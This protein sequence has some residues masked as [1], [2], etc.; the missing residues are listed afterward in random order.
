MAY[1]LVTAA[2]NEAALIERTLRSVAAQTILPK[3]WIIVSDGST[4]RTEEIARTYAARLPF[5]QVIR[6]D[7]DPGRSFVSKVY[8]VQEGFRRVRGLPFEFVGNLDADLSFDATYFEGLLNKFQGDPTLGVGGGWIL[9][10]LGGV[11]QPRPLNSREWVPHAVQLLRRSCYEAVGDYVPMPYGGEDAS[12]VVNARMRGWKA[13]SFHDL[14]VQHHRRTASAGGLLR[15]RFRAGLMD[16]SLGYHP[17]YELMK[18]AR[19]VPERPYVVGTAIWFAG[20]AAGYLRRLPR[21]VS[22]E[23][24]K[25]IR[26]E[27]MQRFKA[28]LNRRDVG[29]RVDDYA[30]RG[31]PDPEISGTSLDGSTRGFSVTAAAARPPTEHLL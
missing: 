5:I 9:E 30:S 16:Y 12:A 19:R 8:A 10:E 11:Y 27:Q 3:A 31:A 18:C 22:S 6:I 23:F 20:F 15:N 2:Y 25:F 17:A 4:D 21:P 7:R 29:H 26:R 24:V 1:V 28:F 14:P 13:E